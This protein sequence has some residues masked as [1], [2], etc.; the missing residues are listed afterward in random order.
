L[1]SVSGAAAALG[2]CY[3]ISAAGLRSPA[4][5]ERNAF[6]WKVP[7]HSETKG[8]GRGMDGIYI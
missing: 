4:A 5:G 7:S 8:G 1:L 3:P 2:S 6:C